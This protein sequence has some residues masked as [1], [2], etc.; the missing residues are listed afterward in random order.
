MRLCPALA[1]EVLGSDGLPRKLG[2]K[3]G[4]SRALPT[5]AVALR[6]SLTEV[7]KVES[8]MIAAAVAALM[9]VWLG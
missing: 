7:L 5:V 1:P 6:A 9:K 4:L 2:G 8:L 3:S